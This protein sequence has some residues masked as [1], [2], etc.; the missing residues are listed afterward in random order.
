MRHLSLALVFMACLVLPVQAQSITYDG[1]DAQGLQCAAEMFIVA[2]LLG[3]TGRLS[4]QKTETAKMLSIAILAQLP[5]TDEQKA[6]AMKQRVKRIL[7]TRT[8]KQLANDYSRTSKWCQRE[9]LR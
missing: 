9:F 3:R 7:Q 4:P 6:Q 2:D 5:G 8:L 1:R